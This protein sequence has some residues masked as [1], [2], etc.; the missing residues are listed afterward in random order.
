MKMDF[1]KQKNEVKEYIPQFIFDIQNIITG[2]MVIAGGMITSVF[3]NKPINDIDIYLVNIGLFDL[4]KILTE[5][6]THSRIV[7][8]SNKSIHYSY[9]DK[10]INL[11]FYKLFTQDVHI[12]ETFDFNIV[13][14]FYNIRKS[15]LYVSPKFIEDNLNKTLTFNNIVSPINELKRIDKYVERGYTIN[16]IEMVKL[17]KHS[18]NIDF[19]DSDNLFENLIG[20]Y[21]EQKQTTDIHT[22]ELRALI[23]NDTVF[24]KIIHKYSKYGKVKKFGKDLQV[25]YQIINLLNDIIYIYKYDTNTNFVLSRYND[26]LLFIISDKLLEL[27]DD[28]TMV[29]HI[30]SIKTYKDDFRI[31]YTSSLFDTYLIASDF[32]TCNYNYN[33]YIID[34]TDITKCKYQRIYSKKKH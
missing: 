10:T 28:V 15:Q 2:E 12:I 19:T 27:I 7:N 18:K 14:G 13:C 30:T 34:I 22:K 1:T 21:G 20:V 4:V 16:H 5:L 25:I 32:N 3:T 8:V 6:R 24:N 17:L 26:E 29:K 31:D 23:D 11:I 9:K 33:Y